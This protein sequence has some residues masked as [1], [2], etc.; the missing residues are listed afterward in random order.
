MTGGIL[1]LLSHSIYNDVLIGNPSL[2]FFKFK[3][4]KYSD[5][6]LQ[7]FCTYCSSS[8]HDLRLNEDTVLQFKLPKYGDL[9]LDS[10][11]CIDLPDIYSPLYNPSI[12]TNNKWIGY[13]YKWIEDIGTQMIRSI[14]IVCGQKIIQSYS[15]SYLSASANRDLSYEKKRLFNEMSGNV[16]ELYDP[17]NAHDRVNAYP[18]TYYQVDENN[19]SIKMEPSIRGRKLSIPLH[20]WY[21]KNTTCALPVKQL[22]NIPLYINITIRPIYELCR[23]RDIRNTLHNHP[24]IQPD[25]TN[26]IFQM[27]RFLQPPPSREINSLSDSYINKTQTWNTNAHIIS[28]YCFL[29]QEEAIL[30]TNTSQHYLIK[31][32]VEHK[33]YNIVGTQKIRLPN[34]K[35]LVSNWMFFLQRNDVSLRNEWNNYTNWPYST[36]PSNIIWAP[37]II[38]HS[39]PDPGLTVSNDK[40]NNIYGPGVNYRSDESME[41]TG[42]YITDKYYE[43]NHKTILQNIAIYFDGIVREDLHLSNVYNYI[44]KYN[45]TNG[46]LTDDIYSYNFALN[47][48]ST[49]TQPSGAI[50]I[51]YFK[52]IEIEIQ[53]FI[54]AIDN[55]TTVPFYIRCD[56][57]GNPVEVTRKK[58]WDIYE[59]HYNFILYEEKYNI[60]TIHDGVVSTMMI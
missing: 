47:A 49:D 22:L 36:I 57:V 31:E 16:K 24:Y 26:E 3:Y 38:S 52:R 30:F 45:R 20:T 53:T 56:T 40:K 5:F 51:S 48:S 17:S 6:G 25:M 59:Y 14:E 21:S 13:E 19:N 50:N 33:I 23:V 10:T 8:S 60:V 9:L 11:L 32:I 54:P 18:S 41:N 34:S 4:T 28:T 29:S 58:P 7:R 35:G 15:G 27:Y 55:T 46:Y 12:L 44:E 42:L 39:Y 2:S 1:N 37:S 43:G